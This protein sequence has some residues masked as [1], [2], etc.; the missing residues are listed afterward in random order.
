MHESL[1]DVA[2]ERNGLRRIIGTYR[3]LQQTYGDAQ[4]LT[5]HAEELRYAINTSDTK[6]ARRILALIE[7]ELDSGGIRGRW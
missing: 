6:R 2:K 5:A 3:Q 7:W 4:P 1:T